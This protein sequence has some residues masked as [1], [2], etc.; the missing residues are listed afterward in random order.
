MFSNTPDYFFDFTTNQ[1]WV[2]ATNTTSTAASLLTTVRSTVKNVNDASGA[3]VSVPSNTLA[4]SN[5]GALIEEGR[6]NLFLNSQAPV[7]Q[8]IT[9][10]N[11]STYAISLYG[12][13]SITLSGALTGVVTQGNPFI[14]AATTTTLTCTVAGTGGTFVN[15]QVE[16]GASATSPIITAGT[17]VARAADV[18]TMTAPPTFGSAYTLYAAATPQTPTNFA[19]IQFAACISDGS[20]NNR[21][22]LNRSATLNQFNGFSQSAGAS[23]TLGGGAAWAQNTIGKSAY[24][25]KTGA[26]AFAF[27]GTSVFT[28]VAGNLPVAVN[29]VAVGVNQAGSGGW[30]DGFVSQL[31]IWTSL[32]LSSFQLQTVTS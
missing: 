21:L 28:S 25:T 16:L 9:V 20:A 26:Q 19:G 4:Q 6:T 8:D 10:V 31:A 22:V 30:F 32:N 24:S 11:A 13:G 7:T 27:N 29:A 18:V 12:T 23:T 3:W 14:G 1:A 2:K 5:L 17:S 15:A